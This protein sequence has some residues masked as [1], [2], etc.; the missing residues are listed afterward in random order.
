MRKSSALSLLLVLLLAYFSGKSQQ[1]FPS[2]TT[3]NAYIKV[4]A[5]KQYERSKLHQA[6]WGNH[7]RKEWATPVTVN[8]FYLDSE[9][10][11]L[12]PY[13]AGGGR[14][15]KTLKLRNP[16]DREYVL[17]SID[18]D[19]GKALP[20]IFQG[21]FVHR[22]VR[23]QGSVAHPYGA[24]TIPSMAEAAKIY[25]TNPRI[26]YVPSQAALQNHNSEFGN[27]LY[28]FEQRPDDNWEDAPN[29]G[30]SKMIIS[31]EDLLKKLLSGSDQKV[32]Q[33]AYIRA[34]LF[35]IFIGDWG[36]HEDQWR[37]AT[38]EESGRTIYRPI[39]RDRDQAFTKFDGLLLGIGKSAA[40]MSYLQTFD[41]NIKDIKS[42]N[43]YARNLDRRMANEMVMNDWVSVAKELQHLL[44]DKVIE[45]SVRKLP[46]EVFPISGEEIIAK[47]KSRRSH[48]TEY[49]EEYYRFLAEEVDIPG[50][51][52]KEFFEVIRLNDDE[53]TVKLFRIDS[54]GNVSKTPFYSR[55]FLTDETKEIRVY[56]IA[57][58][59]IYHIDGEVNEAITVR[60]IGGTGKDVYA[61]KSA[62]KGK[63]AFIYDDLNNEII[64]S[65][66]TVVKLTNDPL[67]PS[68]QYD[69]FF[70]DKKGFKP[71][72]FYDYPDRLYVGLGYKM[73]NYKWERTPFASM[74][75]VHARYSISQQAFSFTYEGFVNQFIGKW[76]LELFGNY[77][78]V[79]WANFFGLGNETQE[80]TTNL[81]Y[82]RMRSQEGY[83]RIGLSRQFGKYL[84]LSLSPFYRSVDI[85]KDT[86]RFVFAEFQDGKNLFVQNQFGGG[87]VNLLFS[88]INHPA[89][90]TKGVVLMGNVEYGRNLKES[91]RDYTRY[92]GVVEFYVPVFR[93]LTARVKTGASTVT[94]EPEFYQM[95]PIGGVWTVKGLR[96]DRY[97]G[98]TSFYSSQELQYL[99]DV[100][101]FLFNGKAGVLGFYDIG[102]V[103]LDGEE[104]NKWHKGFGGGIILAPFNKIAVA[105]TYGISEKDRLFQ[106]RFN[107]RL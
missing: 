66:E 19:F 3:K 73:I 106:L 98:T 62:A 40:R 28:L 84:T 96:R 44:T 17:R 56:G 99:F 61:D 20:E 12:H 39:P 91:S 15:T 67:R 80:V 1:S 94:G 69:A 38:F 72:I 88:S 22:I 63:R 95:N 9:N 104:S 100:K 58:N 75:A 30:N 103:W 10:G 31:T 79:R 4:V 13:E 50:T 68:Y 53:T 2:D 55:K 57:E 54:A 92:T 24:L 78:L 32:D 74:H 76:N 41:N 105:A 83:A 21:T 102:R 18:K 25:H 43:F 5:G 52:Q 71:E 64:T 23:D 70:Y 46:P 11:G 82:Y 26:V 59:D 36:R 35:D 27:D 86:G 37:W 90:P 77:D 101:G 33:Q 81:D 34:R 65:R 16:Q 97:W 87:Y 14:Q 85:I 107:R 49:A 47:L 89:I 60:L 42:Y 48:L 93:N 7:Y 8:Q 6:L 29:F 51:S 45:A